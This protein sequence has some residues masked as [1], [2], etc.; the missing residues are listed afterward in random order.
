[1]SELYLNGFRVGFSRGEFTA[2]VLPMLENQEFKLLRENLRNEWFLYWQEGVCYG[3]PKTTNPVTR[4]GE[5]RSLKCAEHLKVLIARI[6]EVLPEKFPQYEAFR[7]RPFTFRGKKEEMVEA[8]RTVVKGLPPV[9]GGFKIHP[10]FELDARLIELREGALEVGLFL[11]VSTSW[12]ISASLD[13]L[14][15]AGVNVEGLYVVRRNPEPEQRRLAGRIRQVT[16][17]KVFLS[18]SFDG[19]ESVFADDVMLEGSRASFSQC[20]KQILGGRYESFERERQIQEAKCLTGPALDAMISRMGGY[21]AKASPVTLCPGLDCTFGERIA[22]ENI[23]LYKTFVV[24]PPVEYCFDAARSKRHK[25]AWLGLDRFGPFSRDAF[26]RKSP[27][28]LVVFPDSVQGVAERFLRYFRDGINVEHGN[29]AYSGG[30]ATKFGLVNPEFVFCRVPWLA[31]PSAKPAQVYRKALEDFLSSNGDF[32]AA[33]VI[34]LNEHEKLPETDNPYLHSKAVL[35]MAGIP[36]QAER[37]STIAQPETGLQYSLQNISVALYAKLN[38]IPWTV[39]H[40]LTIADELVIG[41]GTCELLESRFV[42]KQRFI[43]ITTVFRGDGNYLLS[44]L[45]SECSYDDYPAVL[46][47]STVEILQEIKRRNGWQKG[48]TVRVVVHSFKPLKNVEVGEIMKRCVE[49]VGSE[50]NIEFAF[51]TVTQEHAFM[52]MDKE[53]TGISVKGKRDAMKAVFVPSRGLISQLGSFTRLLC[54]NGPE[55]IKRELSP[56]PAPLL[57]HIHPESTYRDLA[58]LSEQVLKF[59][60]LSWRSTLPA[61]LP[62][63]IYYSDLIAGLLSRLKSV[64]DWSPA[65]LNV[66]LRASKWFL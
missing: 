23:G 53:Q 38:G 8:I 22:V 41:V 66:K 34:V 9:V 32:D 61:K 20:L 13:E 18:E 42:E 51:L 3:L 54:T 44:N 21:L 49:T 12:V 14:I 37:V 48:D 27:R 6:H 46:E 43:G 47:K 29:S 16:G 57:I 10:K 15:A 59:T 17:Q 24:A 45:S 65:M 4:F 50:Q 7:R 19:V 11:V 58:S 55:L 62:V 2:Y 26:A 63:T 33:I 56:L 31:K 35:L 64:P 25:Y 40:D 1:M 60:S 52:I 36:V 39:D 5:Q 30:F 28:V